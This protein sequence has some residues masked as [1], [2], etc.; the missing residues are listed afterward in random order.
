MTE[1]TNL[2][3]LR[4]AQV[5][6]MVDLSGGL[7]V[8]AFTEH[9]IDARTP[10]ELVDRLYATLAYRQY[11]LY[12]READR[13]FERIR[14]R[15]K[16]VRGSL[17][18]YRKRLYKE[19]AAAASIDAALSAAAPSG[20]GTFRRREAVDAEIKKIAGYLEL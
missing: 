18:R 11:P 2:P 19:R 1:S 10:P 20:E 9:S 3:P 17:A 15:A 8:S 4:D 16:H 6:R 7:G 14:E 13:I 5:S 12:A